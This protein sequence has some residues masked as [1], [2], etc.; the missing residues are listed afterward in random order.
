MS[1]LQVYDR[2]YRLC[3]V[4][5]S[6]WRLRDSVLMTS[7]LRFSDVGPSGAD[8]GILRGG[9]GLGSRSAGIFIY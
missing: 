2:I 8:L 1:P 9:L 3:D 6:I 7:G 4:E 5:N